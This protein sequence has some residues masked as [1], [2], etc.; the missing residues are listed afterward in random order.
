[1]VDESA[2]TS[3]Q[4]ET[5]Q[6]AGRVRLGE[7]SDGPARACGAR[8]RAYFS[9]RGQGQVVMAIA[10]AAALALFV[11]C[12]SAQ[13]PDSAAQCMTHAARIFPSRGPGYPG[14]PPSTLVAREMS[15]IDAFWGSGVRAAPTPQLHMNAASPAGGYIYYDPEFLAQA[16]EEQTAVSPSLMILAHEFGHQ[17]QFA[18]GTRTGGILDELGADCYSGYFFGFLVCKDLTSSHDIAAAFREMCELGN[19]GASV[20]WWAPDAHGDCCQRSV[21]FLAGMRAYLNGANPLPACTLSSLPP[22]CGEP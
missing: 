19:Q 8:P 21:A 12:A 3:R 15:A 13:A 18:Y 17:I 14:Y 10:S 2:T 7:T 6:Q 4:Q 22:T 9:E 1:M 20:P 11:G 16:D 5:T